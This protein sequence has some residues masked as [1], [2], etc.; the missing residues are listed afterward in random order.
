M[1]AHRDDSTV[2]CTCAC[3]LVPVGASTLSLPFVLL[4]VD[5]PPQFIIILCLVQSQIVYL[6]TPV[7]TVYC[8]NLKILSFSSLKQGMSCLEPQGAGLSNIQ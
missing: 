8:C 1:Q 2:T 5:L 6:C 7:L 3:S 4:F